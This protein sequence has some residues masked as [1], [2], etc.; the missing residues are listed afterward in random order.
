MSTRQSGTA[1]RVW[2]TLLSLLA[3]LVLAAGCGPGGGDADPSEA[4]DG[5]TSADTTSPPD[6]SLE[7]EAAE[8]PEAESTGVEQTGETQAARPSIDV[9]G[10]PIGG[11]GDGS[12]EQCV[13][14]SYLGDDPIPRD[15]RITIDD[16]SLRDPGDGSPSDAFARL[17]GAC[18][19][20]ASCRG[21]V[22]TAENDEA[23]AQ[24]SFLVEA[25]Q[26]PADDD[27][28]FHFEGL[29]LTVTGTVSCP[30]GGEA[31]CEDFRDR[32]EADQDPIGLSVPVADPTESSSSSGE[33]SSESSSESSGESSSESSSESSTSESS[34][35]DTTDTGQN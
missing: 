1:G 4:A 2:L 31:L 14:V 7:T 28:P 8:D 12:V 29:S 18:G 6:G 32:L 30:V 10:L 15:V 16:G 20:N 35:G 21:F 25:T 22:F 13:A 24:C 26:P 9:A 23:G 17:A 11:D 19:G 5:G 3:A 34:T 33:S 27:A